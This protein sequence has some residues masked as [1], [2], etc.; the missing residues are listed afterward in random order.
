MV[1][2]KTKL[3]LSKYNVKAIAE[4]IPSHCPHSQKER[5]MVKAENKDSHLLYSGLPW[6]WFTAEFIVSQNNC[7]TSR[8]AIVIHVDNK[9]HPRL[10]IKLMLQSMMVSLSQVLLYCTWNSSAS[11]SFLN[12]LSF[13][14][15]AI[16]RPSLA[17]ISALR[18]ASWERQSIYNDYITH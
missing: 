17:V 7:K 16:R 8:T 18:A 4:D 10:V 5:I 1:K 3:Q 13:F 2:K 11:I 15:I 14:S 6:M 12:C 9:K